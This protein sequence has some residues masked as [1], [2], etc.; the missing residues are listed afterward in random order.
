MDLTDKVAVIT[1]AS[2]GLGAGLAARLLERGL[3]VGVDQLQSTPQS[4]NRYKY[5]TYEYV[6]GGFAALV[7]VFLLVSFL[8]V[9]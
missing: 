4:L 7:T 9:V 8:I 3:K 6:I 1:G 5:D 2:R